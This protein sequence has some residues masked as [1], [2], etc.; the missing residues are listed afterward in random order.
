MDLIS[1]GIIGL[2]FI[3]LIV[4]TVLSA[5]TWHWVN[6][7]FVNLTFI[8]GVGASIGLSQALHLRQRDM[9]DLE[10]SQKSAEENKIAAELAVSGRPDSSTYDRSSLRGI[11]HEMAMVMAGRGRVWSGGKVT[12]EG[13]NRIFQF[14]TARP[15]VDA[16]VVQLKDVTLHLFADGIIFEKPYPQSYVG[17]IVVTEEST[18]KLTLKSVFI[19]NPEEWTQPTTT[20]SLFEKMPL[21]RHDT[22]KMRIVAYVDA[23]PDTATEQEKQLAESIRKDE[24][25][26]GPFRELLTNVIL[27]PESFNFDPANPGPEYE[28][29]IDQ[30]AFDGFSLGQ[31]QNWID[32]N[33]AKR[34]S[35]RFEPLPAEVFVRYRFKKASKEPYVVDSE[36][37]TLE[38]EGLFTNLGYAIDPALKAGAAV[39]FNEG[40]TVLVD[41]LT[42]EG[43]RGNEQV[44]KFQDKEEVEEVDR[45]YV[46]KLRD[47]PYLFANLSIQTKKFIEETERVKATIVVQD[48]SHAD[49]EAQL[50]DRLATNAGLQQD[51]TNLQNDLDTIIALDK[52]RSD[53]VR[54]LAAQIATLK[55]QIQARYDRIQELTRTVERQVYAEK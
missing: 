7:V 45:V 19:V 21:D 36:G 30:Y 52:L 1:A 14:P 20:W 53:E 11:T 24:M 27:K 17:S 47:F 49:A 37:G 41:Q 31:I 55:N 16:S 22:F 51:N 8:A 35:Q 34:I 23:N 54:N 3:L 46:R 2:V 38:T 50:A 18:E 9:L 10:Q 25:Q 39:S 33:T 48:K 26:I 5:K 43:Q 28:K 42:A 29:L 4:I 12:V 40:D 44:P 13:D 15:A 32:E 6:I